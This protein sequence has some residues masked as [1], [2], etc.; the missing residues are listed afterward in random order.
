LKR[1]VYPTRFELVTS[2][3]GEQDPRHQT[4]DDNRIILTIQLF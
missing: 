3:F 2:A 1:L 4:T